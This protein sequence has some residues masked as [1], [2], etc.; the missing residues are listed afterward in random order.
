MT[1]ATICQR[2]VAGAAKV[3]SGVRVEWHDALVVDSRPRIYFANHGSHLDFV[4]VWSALPSSIRTTTRPVAARDYW[5][6]SRVRRYLASTVFNALL[7][8]R[9]RVRKDSNPVDI[10]ADALKNGESIILFPEGTRGLDGEVADFKPGLWH[11]AKRMPDVP[12]VPVYLENLNRVL[13]KGEFL[14]IPLLSWCHFGG[15]EQLNEREDKATFLSRMR[16]RLL[17]L[18]KAHNDT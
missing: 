10:F 13:P 14:P 1:V 9:T 4:V 5:S 3:I 2:L 12:L 16:N 6:N 18:S 8:D 7:V 15:P 11:I 17:D